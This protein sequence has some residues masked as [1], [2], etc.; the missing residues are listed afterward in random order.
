MNTLSSLLNWLGNTIGANPSTL[1]TTSKTLVG[2]INEIEP[3]GSVKMY[4]GANAPSGWLKCD[5]S[6]VSRTTYA[7]LFTAIGTTYGTGD[8]SNTFNLPNLTD[9]MP[10]GAGNL[11]SLGAKGGSKDAVVPYHR[12]SVSKITNGTSSSGSH[13]HTV[14]H[15]PITAETF[16]GAQTFYYAGQTNPL[17]YGADTTASA[18]AHQHDI[19]AHNTDYAGTSGNT[20][21]ANLPPYIAMNYIIFAGV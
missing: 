9:R 16:S 7:A 17:Y 12:H 3:V 19:N 10:I 8:G 13:S 5:G 1:K 2:A 4:A 21:N 18:G 14:N 15:K 20:T 6:A 11:Y